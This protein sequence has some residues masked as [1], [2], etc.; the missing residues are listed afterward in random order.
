MK[1]NATSNALMC[2]VYAA[3]KT[4]KAQQ[5]HIEELKSALTKAKKHVE[6]KFMLSHIDNVL[7]NDY[8]RTY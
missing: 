1:H 3:R 2:E 6:D 5:E 8:K 7:A 4:L